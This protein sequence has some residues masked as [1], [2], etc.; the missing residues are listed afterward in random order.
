MIFRSHI[1]AILFAG[2]L[3]FSSSAIAQE[4]PAAPAPKPEPLPQANLTL[5]ATDFSLNGPFSG[6]QLIVSE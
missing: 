5:Q 6:Q 1:S 4:Q 3:F 2:T